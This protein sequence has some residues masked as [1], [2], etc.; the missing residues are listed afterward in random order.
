MS[1]EQ[2]VSTWLSDASITA[3]VGSRRALSQL[4]QNTAYPALVY[5]VVTNTPAPHLNY[6]TER[7][8]SVA[9]VQLNPLAR[10]IATIKSIHSALRALLDFRHN[11]V[12]AGKTIIS[13]RLGVAGVVEKDNDLGIWTQSA[14]YVLR[15]YE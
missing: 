14:D 5:Q 10:D 11:I 7:Q 9:R 3:L 2:I 15:Y 6:A 1:A 4:P 12:I 8:E 13:C